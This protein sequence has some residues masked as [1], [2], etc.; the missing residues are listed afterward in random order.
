MT[1][2]LAAWLALASARAAEAAAAGAKTVSLPGDEIEL[3]TADGWTLKARYKAAEPGKATAVLLHGRGMRKEWWLRLARALTKAGYGFLAPDLGGHGES[4]T[5]PDGQ[6]L[7]WRK[8]KATRHE[9]DFEAM[10][11]DI[12]AVVA[13]LAQDTVAE[14]SIALIGQDVGGSVALKYA[15]VHPKISLLVMLSPGLKYQEVT[16]VNAMRA[17]KNRPVLLVYGE[18]DK[19]ASREAP[20]LYQFA[21]LSVGEGRATV[22]AIPN[23]PGH[24]L[25]TSA[26]VRQIVDWL[27]NPLPPEPPQASSGTLDADVSGPGVDENSGDAPA[28]DDIR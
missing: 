11:N 2:L 27:G 14:E 21:K 16:T 22:M 26:V 17:Y 23:L 13:R 10:A 4:Q 8:M 5:A 28:L 7:H 12:Q 1:V 18:L 9:N 15:A 20:I 25:L 24:K 3:K 6:T 19:T